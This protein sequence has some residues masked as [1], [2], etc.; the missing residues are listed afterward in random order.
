MLLNETLVQTVQFNKWTI[1]MSMH[2]DVL[3]GWLTNRFRF[4]TMNFTCTHSTATTWRYLFWWTWPLKRPWIRSWTSRPR[5]FRSRMPLCKSRKEHREESPFGGN[6]STK[7]PSRNGMNRMSALLVWLTRH[8][9]WSAT[10][11]LTRN[12]NCFFRIARPWWNCKTFETFVLR[13]DAMKTWFCAHL[14]PHSVCRRTW[15]LPLHPL[16]QVWRALWKSKLHR[17][18][19]SKWLESTGMNKCRTSFRRF[20]GKNQ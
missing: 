17:S 11:I 7:A 10:K 2:T 1:W 20:M 6:T 3:R 14:W 4:R 15:P 9:I 13:L 8:F 16:S 18:N 19:E 5:P 12:F